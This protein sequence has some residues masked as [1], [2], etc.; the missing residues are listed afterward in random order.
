M[1]EHFADPSDGQPDS[2][3]ETARPAAENPK[4]PETPNAD[5]ARDEDLR[6]AFMEHSID[7]I[8]I[9]EY[10]TAA[11]I[12][13]NSAFAEMLGYSVEEVRRMHV[14]DWDAFWSREELERRFA[15][16]DW[17]VNRFETCH[18]H[19]DGRVLD[20]TI[21]VTNVC[22]KEKQVAFC[23]VR[24]ISEPKRQERK[25]QQELARWQLLMERSNDGIVILDG[26]S[27]DV[28]DVN[29]AFAQMLGYTKEELAGMHP[30]DWDACFTRAEIETMGKTHRDLTEERRFETRHL[31]KDGTLLDVEINST[32]AEKGDQLLI[33]CFCRD[34]TARNQAERLLRARE[35]EFRTLAENSPDAIV[36][37]DGQLHRLYV[38]PSFELLVGKDKK[39]LLGKPLEDL[40]TVDLT[41]YRSA[42][43][44][45]FQSTRQQELE[46]CHIKSDGSP[47]WAH[48]RYE[49]EFDENGA[50]VS[51]L[52]VM[53]DISDL[54]RQRDLARQLAFTD[55]LTG[56]P[57]RALFEKRFQDAANRAK[58]SCKP[59]A[60]LMLDI[61]HFKDIN[62]TLGH[63]TGDEL[64]RQV[65]MRLSRFIRERDTI[66]RLGGDEF[67][68]LLNTIPKTEDTTEVATRV[69]DALAKP[70]Q[71]DGQEL[72]VSG[73]IGIALYPRD[74]DELNEL[75]TFADTAL[76][77]AKRKGRNNY[78]F[79]SADL[80]RHATERM[81]LGAALRQAS[82]SNE[83]QLL[84]QPKVHLETGRIIGGEALVR[85]HHPELG[86]LT[87]DRFITIAEENGSIIGIGQWVLQQACRAAIL[88]NRHR[89]SPFKVAVNL[90]CRQFVQHDLA[91][92]VKAI[93][94]T[95]GCRGEWLEFEITESLMIEDN[96]KVLNTLEEL[97]T[98]GI[99][100]AIDDFGTGYSA[101]SYLNRFPMD[102][103][104]ID[105]S[106][107]DGIDTDSRKSGLVNSFIAVGKTLGMEVVA[108]GVETSDQSKVLLNL[109]CGLGQGYLFGK[110]RSFEEFM[111]DLPA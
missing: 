34:I 78:Q 49:P 63:Q 73:S 30:W 71:I 103:L 100:I 92:E 57:N 99:S 8:V 22:W 42:L 41:E 17:P 60:L 97:R 29:P 36:R 94:Q 75:F 61:D 37:Y 52:V 58:S 38:N 89:P 32:P 7:G 19:K 69:L 55:T 59:F 20:V 26:E 93:L 111:S 84:Y 91:G 45:A 15:K 53:R 21:S 24:D 43:Q 101:L 40:E 16:H 48:I 90:S 46:F 23:V 72:F 102:V 67:V 54:V 12:D 10:D 2:A 14:W 39:D 18:R 107:V 77:S 13:T 109:G 47:C 25:L 83:L 81:S 62:D 6:L 108:E 87:P 66:A 76:Y 9:I 96:R 3:S 95:T 27:L 33:F 28:V 11:V 5:V 31:R 79:Y 65:T 35:R 88:F 68:I 106:F 4:F 74:S 44:M 64:L 51:V 105:R 86:M 80:T 98:L 110:P 50:V 1:S 104:K 70:F 85:W 82:V 56:L